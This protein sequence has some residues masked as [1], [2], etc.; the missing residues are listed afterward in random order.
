[1][2]YLKMGYI[3]GYKEQDEKC[4]KKQ[5]DYYD[6]YNEKVDEYS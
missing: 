2:R 1:M 5:K 6:K 4:A 3:K